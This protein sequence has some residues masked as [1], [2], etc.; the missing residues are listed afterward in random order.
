MGKLKM[1]K[2]SPTTDMTPLVDL[3]FL[4]VTFFMLSAKFR[5][6]EPVQTDP[7]Y[8]SS[9]D[10]IPEKVMLITISE[11]GRVFYDLSGK[12][13][14]T[15]LL[16]GMAEIYPNLKTLNQDQVDKFIGLGSFGQPIA[17]LPAYLSG[18]EKMREAM[19]KQTK[20]IPIDSLNNELGDWIL[21]GF[22]AFVNDVRAK[23]WDDARIKKEGLRYAIKADANTDYKYVKA[24]IDVF[25]DRQI[26]Q[27]NMVTNVEKDENVVTG[28]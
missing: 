11:D 2:G 23:G 25:R 6:A 16:S 27:F 26:F 8:S 18:D 4:L 28:E 14:R 15:L 24:V 1:P 10:Q 21:Q 17:Q 12:D 3:G 7:P 13:V 20:G 22:T 9:T 19:N 5:S